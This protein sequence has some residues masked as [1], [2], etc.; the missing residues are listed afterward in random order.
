MSND[1]TASHEKILSYRLFSMDGKYTLK[2]QGEV[3]LRF[4]SGAD[5]KTPIVGVGMSLEGSSIVDPVLIP[6]GVDPLRVYE[7]MHVRLQG[8]TRP[9][10][11]NSFIGLVRGSLMNNSRPISFHGYYHTFG[12]PFEDLPEGTYYMIAQQNDVDWAKHPL[13]TADSEGSW[14]E[15]A[16]LS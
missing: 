14:S 2:G 5:G 3:S 15:E 9:V 16:S 6:S 11:V 13:P 1:E 7:L 8:Q 12:Q 4:T 10:R